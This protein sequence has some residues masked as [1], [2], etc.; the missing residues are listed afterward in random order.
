MVAVSSTQGPP[1]GAARTGLGTRDALPP[2]AAATQGSQAMAQAAA[3]PAVQRPIAKGRPEREDRSAQHEG[4]PATRLRIPPR[5]SI[6][7]SPSPIWMY[8]VGQTSLQ[9]WQPMHLS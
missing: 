9:M 6:G 7:Y 8:P 1:A 3:A 5:G 4:R 2:S